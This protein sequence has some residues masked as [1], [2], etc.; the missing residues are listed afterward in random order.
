MLLRF[1]AFY[2]GIQTEKR[3]KTAAVI[4]A[5]TAISK[6]RIRAIDVNV[7]ALNQSKYPID[8]LGD[9]FDSS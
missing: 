2:R 1:V 3:Y 8:G 6:D 9:A 7:R 4:S 5:F